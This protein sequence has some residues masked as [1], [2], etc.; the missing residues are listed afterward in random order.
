MPDA[1]SH[2]RLDHP[3]F[4]QD[5]ELH[6]GDDGVP[7]A[8]LS[9]RPLLG[10]PARQGSGRCS[11]HRRQPDV[12]RAGDLPDARRRDHG[13]RVA[14]RWRERSRSGVARVQ[15]VASAL[16]P[17]RW[18]LSDRIDGA[19]RPLRRFARR[20]PA[21]GTAGRRVPD[22]VHPRDGAA[23]RDGRHGSGA[24]WHRQFQAWDD[25]RNRDGH[26]QHGA[27]AVSHLRLGDGRPSWCRWRGDLV[28]GR[29]R[30]WCRLAGD[31][32]REAWRVPAFRAVAVGATDIALGSRC[33]RLACRPAPSSR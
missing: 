25:R 24:P 29:G 8:V 16:G 32:L 27:G 18:D 4:A 17:G 28:A 1:G 10:R 22:L 20:R 2:H 14:C 31:V 21:D 15:S 7:D 26:P 11:R 19:P 23:V 12:H 6:A 33:S 5:R 3:P 9:R 13:P 30:G